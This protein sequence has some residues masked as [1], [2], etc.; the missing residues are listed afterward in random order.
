LCAGKLWQPPTQKHLARVMISCLTC[1]A[2]IQ[3]MNIHEAKTASV[4]NITALIAQNN[5]NVK[6]SPKVVFHTRVP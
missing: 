6:Q 2:M 5:I 4:T 3:Q 1:P